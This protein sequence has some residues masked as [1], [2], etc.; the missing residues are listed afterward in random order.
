M[1]SLANH[2]SRVRENSEV[3]IIYPDYPITSDSAR[4]SQKLRFSVAWKIAGG[5][6]TEFHQQ[7]VCGLERSVSSGVARLKPGTL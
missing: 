1:I 2:D 3:V 4:C 6:P 7:K 5:E